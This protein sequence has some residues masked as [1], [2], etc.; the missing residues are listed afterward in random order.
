MDSIVIYTDGGAR[1]NPGPAGAGIVIYEGEK[2]ISELKQYL[3]ERQTNNWAEYEAVAIALAE[4]RRLGFSERALEIRMD[5]MLVVEQLMGNWKI[6]EPAL[7]MQATKVRALLSY[8]P[9]S[10][11]FTR[12]SRVERG[13]RC[14]RQRSA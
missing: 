6:K 13:S 14:A 5:S 8:F 9:D 11:F 12:A 10:K 3:G 7:K 1:W 2:K 4:A